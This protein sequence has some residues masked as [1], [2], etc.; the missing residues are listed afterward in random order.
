MGIE[1]LVS[2]KRP[3]LSQVTHMA[4]IQPYLRKQNVALSC[5]VMKQRMS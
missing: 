5:A 1:L 3:T 2:S 4:H